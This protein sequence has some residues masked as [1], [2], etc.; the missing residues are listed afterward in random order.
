VTD[1]KNL[2][3]AYIVVDTNILLECLPTVQ[4]LFRTLSLP[5][6]NS[7]VHILVPLTVLYGTLPTFDFSRK[8]KER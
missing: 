2:V 5:E 4:A 6:L 1:I 8:A 3:R 7:M